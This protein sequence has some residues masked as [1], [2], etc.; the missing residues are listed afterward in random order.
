MQ[1]RTITK[2][3]EKLSP[4][5]FGAMRLTTTMSGT[6]LKKAS[7]EITYAIN[8]GVNLIDTAY[9][10][11][12]GEN[13]KAIGEILKKTGLRNKVNISTKMNRLRIKTYNDMHKMFN[14]ELKN[15]QTDHIDYYFI[16]NII[17]YEDIEKLQKNDLNKFIEEKKETGEIRN[18]GFSYHGPSNQFQKIVDSYPWDMCL[19]QYNYLDENFQAGKKGIQYLHEKGI[20]IIIME[21][22]KGGLLAGKLPPE[23]EKLKKEK[24][25]T[26]SNADLGL[27]WLLN[28]KEITC[29]LSGMNSLEMV[30]EN[31]K[32]ANT[33][34]VNT[35]KKE[36]LKTIEEIKNIILKLNKINCTSCG[37]C[38]PC[39]RGVSIPECFQTYNEKYL[40]NQKQFGIHE[41]TINYIGGLLGTVGPAQDASL[42]TQCN[43]CVSKC[44]QQLPI[45][46]LLETVNKEFHGNLTKK[47]LPLLRQILKL[48]K[49]I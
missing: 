9:M 47:T 45:P 13:E 31:I 34:Q 29:I 27:S 22:L 32:I 7:Q 24:N 2:T 48:F 11:G 8:N 4:L 19:L 20:G 23:V 14:Q 1:Y 5:G 12:N 49:I 43:A 46:N 41:A 38:M 36:Q 21:P 39:P 17:G 44:P 3:G 25:I 6:D 15:L 30:K 10:Y 37:Y 18:I 35:L 26:R 16:H 42:C 28:Q 40:F 33:T